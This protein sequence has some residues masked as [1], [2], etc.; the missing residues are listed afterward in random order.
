M[1][2]GACNIETLTCGPWIGHVVKGAEVIRTN[3]QS[4]IHQLAQALGAALSQEIQNE[5]MSEQWKNMLA[6][7][8]AAS[9]YQ[10]DQQLARDR[11]IGA[12]RALNGTTYRA[13]RTV[14]DPVIRR[15]QG[16]VLR[17]MANSAGL[18]LRAVGLSPTP[19]YLLAQ[20]A[21][22]GMPLLEEAARLRWI[23]PDRYQAYSHP[24]DTSPLLGPQSTG[25]WTLVMNLGKDDPTIYLQFS[26]TF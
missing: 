21:A 25:D 24:I 26:A 17:V 6:P 2:N 3:D 15:I 10:Q 22:N 7:D 23:T 13:A 12:K 16:T 8:V 14:L 9:P 11:D 1:G 19:A 4:A 5:H 18:T 20:L